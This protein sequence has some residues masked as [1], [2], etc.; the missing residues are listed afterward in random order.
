MR[1]QTTIGGND[2]RYLDVC[3][4]QD[5]RPEPPPTPILFFNIFRCRERKLLLASAIRKMPFQDQILKRG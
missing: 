2:L 3:R 5:R 4:G 1:K